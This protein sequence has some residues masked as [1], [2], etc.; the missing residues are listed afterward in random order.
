M[1]IEQWW[2]DGER[3]PIEL[4]GVERSVF[5]RRL[6]AGPAMTL[7]HGFPSSSYDWAKL[8]PALSERRSLLLLDFLGF[9]A[10]D[11]PRDHEYS[12]VEQADLVEAIFEREGIADTVL[13]VHDYAVSVAQ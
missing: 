11:K 8:V 6:G 1:E 4:G 7:L 5:V 13:V 9:G 12:L 2:S 10:S 3:V